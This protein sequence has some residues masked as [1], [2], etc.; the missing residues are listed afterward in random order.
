M[1]K[2][3]TVYM[4][5]Q[6]QNPPSYFIFSNSCYIPWESRAASVNT[7][8]HPVYCNCELV[9]VREGC[10]KLWR[11]IIY[12]RISFHVFKIQRQMSSVRPFHYI[13]FRQSSLLRPSFKYDWYA[14]MGTRYFFRSPLPLVRYL[15]IV[16]PLPLV[17][18]FQKFGSPLALVRYSAT[19]I[20]SFVRC[21]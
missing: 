1:E 14:E 15:K 10:W 3:A 2:S 21:H 5:K 18:N 19:A 17:R 9:S 8:N 4:M 6:L 13:T 12:S 20:F 16:L 7:S 11:P